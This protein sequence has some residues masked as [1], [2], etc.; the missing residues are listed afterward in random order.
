MKFL[1]LSLALVLASCSHNGVKNEIV[2]NKSEIGKS[3]NLVAATLWVQKSAEYDALCYQAYNI[4]TERLDALLKKHGKKSKKLAIVLD[5]DETVLNNTPF[6]GT[7]I[8]ENEIFD[9]SLWTE[10]VKMQKAIPLAGAKEFLEYADKKGVEIFYVSNRDIGDELEATFANL[11]NVGIPVKKENL[12]FKD[13]KSTKEPR[14]Q[15]VAEKYELAL[16]FGD[17]LIDFAEGFEGFEGDNRKVNVQKRRTDWG[18]RFIVL[19]NPMYGDWLKP[20]MKTKK[21]LRE[22]ATPMK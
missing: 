2:V 17:N 21:P 5:V 10:W 9:Q 18:K 6:Q 12:L 16:L 7:L 22:L 4:A 15:K 11:K 14:R 1:L 3:E 8:K 20:L 13:G 19:P